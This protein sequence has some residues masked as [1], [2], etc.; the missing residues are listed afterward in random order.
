M[1]TRSLLHVKQSGGNDITVQ[2]SVVIIGNE[3]LESIELDYITRVNAVTTVLKHCNGLCI[4]NNPGPIGRFKQLSISFQKLIS[5][6]ARS[7]GAPSDPVTDVEFVISDVVAYVPDT[8]T[9][10]YFPMLEYVT[11][12]VTF[13]TMPDTEFGNNFPIKN[14]HRDL[15]VDYVTSE[16]V[17]FSHLEHVGGSVRFLNECFSGYNQLYF[18]ILGAGFYETRLGPRPPGTGHGPNDNRLRIAHD[19]IIECIYGL[20]EIQLYPLAYIGGSF[21][22][23]IVKQ[24]DPFGRRSRLDTIKIDANVEYFGWFRIKNTA[25]C[26]GSNLVDFIEGTDDEDIVYSVPFSGIPQL[27]ENG[28]ETGEEFHELLVCNTA[29]INL[30][31]P[32]SSD[33]I[34]DEYVNPTA[35]PTCVEGSSFYNDMC[36]S[37]TSHT[38]QDFSPFSPSS[39]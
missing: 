18:I 5:V 1:N 7:P 31:V 6:G 16:E 22:V 27:A 10:I 23:D 29:E 37:C 26:D 17:K 8:T 2:G 25:P 38:G 39:N 35:N 24:P 20:K 13:R 4:Q 14:V 11:G 32:D 3:A 34:Y 21:D 36:E 15:T 28:L 30:P 12:D 33:Y 19:L 9:R